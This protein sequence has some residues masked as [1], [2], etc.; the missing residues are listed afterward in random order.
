LATDGKVQSVVLEGATF[1]GASDGKPGLEN[2]FRPTIEETI[3]ESEFEPTCAAKTVRIG[4]VFRM[5]VAPYITASW[6]GYRNRVE[7]WAVS[8]FI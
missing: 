2:L 6:F 8:P 4:Y 3:R 5:N 7:V 1:P